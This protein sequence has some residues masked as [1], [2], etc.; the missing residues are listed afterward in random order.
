MSVCFRSVVVPVL[1][2]TAVFQPLGL[3]AV[4]LTGGFWGKRQAINLSATLPHI[5]AWLTREGWIENF[6]RGAAGT[7]PLGRRGREF[8]DSEVYKFLEAIAWTLAQ[9][10]LA[11][12]DRSTWEGTFHSIVARVGAAQDDD[13]YLNTNFGRSGQSPRWVNLE[14]GHELYCLGHLFQA[15]VARMRSTPDSNDGLEQIARRAADLV[16]D[17]FGEGG[18]ESVCG[19]PEIEVGLAELARAT[20]EVRYALQAAIFVERRGRGTLA[21]V[22][23]GRAYFQ[24]DIPVRDAHVLRGHAVRANY[25]AAGAVDVAVDSDDPQL[26]GALRCQWE[27]TISRRTYL[28]G[29]QGSHH[30]DES[31][32]ADWELPPDRAYSETCAGIASIM[33]SWR[34][35]LVGGGTQYADLIERTLFNVVATSPSADGR[36]FYYSN[37]LHQRELGHPVDSDQIS[38]R[39]TSAQRAPWFEVSCCPPNVARTLASLAAYVATANESGLQ[40]HQ[41]ASCR[42]RMSLPSGQ[43]VHVDVETAYP[44][45]GVIRV[46][47]ADGVESEIPWTITLRVPTW[48]E[49]ARV[50]V[51]SSDGTVT[52]ETVPVGYCDVT[53]AFRGG[54]EIEFTLPMGPRLTAPDPR[55]DAIRGTVAVERGPE[56]FCLES[57]DITNDSLFDDLRLDPSSSLTYEDPRIIVVMQETSVADNLWPYGGGRPVTISNPQAIRLIPY[58]SWAA[59][60]PSKMRV[61]IPVIKD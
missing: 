31:F 22:E 9:E 60:G 18:I 2:I 57:V 27:A 55:I 54:D 48:A 43:Q 29:G 25:L 59:R 32:G 5:A 19:H 24:D 52:D 35:L 8:S 6:D 36:S 33:F 34:L 45:D 28:T 40:L 51:R 1:P 61:W 13:G 12:T 14:W 11:E 10:D 39:A 16:C 37:T 23:W 47:I 46:Q 53:R 49:S 20:G 38:P 17:V 15:A 7:L 21:D 44:A 50:V 3:D 58:H 4:S 26:L 30:Q 56:V 41:Y 42:I